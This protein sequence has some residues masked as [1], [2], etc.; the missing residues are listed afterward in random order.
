MIILLLTFFQNQPET[1]KYEQI[2][3][4]QNKY[5]RNFEQK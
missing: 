2:Y 5:D 1:Y 4:T 3:L